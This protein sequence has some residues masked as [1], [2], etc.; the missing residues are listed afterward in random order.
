MMSLKS[1]KILEP[2]LSG[3]NLFLCR[4]RPY[5]SIDAQIVALSVVGPKLTMFLW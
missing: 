2:K 4:K 3:L 5:L 1:N